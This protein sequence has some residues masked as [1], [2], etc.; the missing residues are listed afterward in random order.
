[1][2]CFIRG[3]ESCEIPSQAYPDSHTPLVII[4]VQCFNEDS[5]FYIH[6]INNSGMKMNYEVRV[7]DKSGK[8]IETVKGENVDEVLKSAAKLASKDFLAITMKKN[9]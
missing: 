7:T 4:Q 2:K 1:L 9:E 3:Y 6:S 5:N 8:L